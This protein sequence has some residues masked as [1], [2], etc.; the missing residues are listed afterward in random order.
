MKRRAGE[1][2]NGTM[3]PAQRLAMKRLELLQDQDEAI[4]ITIEYMVSQSQ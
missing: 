2:F 3:S 4:A 1:Q